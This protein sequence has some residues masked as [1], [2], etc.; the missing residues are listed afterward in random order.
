M[1]D[2]LE[3]GVF[4][5]EP[6]TDAVGVMERIVIV[7]DEVA[8]KEGER[9]KDRVGKIELLIELLKVGVAE[10]DGLTVMDMVYDPDG[11]DVR[12]LEGELEKDGLKLR[13][14]EDEG[15]TVRVA[16]GVRELVDDLVDDLESDGEREGERESEGVREGER[17]NEG[18]DV[19]VTVCDA[20]SVVV[21]V[22]EP[23]IVDV[24]DI[25]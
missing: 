17:E 19:F 7:V 2:K 12:V 8:V 13:V 16:V 25:V 21:E 14:F 6:V 23:E 22:G 24:D 11:V 3:L 18:D 9:V 20:E 5:S 4:V 1:G 10:G 15:D